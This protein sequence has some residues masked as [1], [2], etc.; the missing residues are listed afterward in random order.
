MEYQVDCCANAHEAQAFM[1]T[2]RFAANPA[3]GNVNVDALLAPYRN[4]ASAKQL[5]TMPSRPPAQIPAEHGLM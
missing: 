3:G 5:L 1:H 4:G 2:E